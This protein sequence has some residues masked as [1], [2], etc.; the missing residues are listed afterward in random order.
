MDVLTRLTRRDKWSLAGGK[1]ALS[2]PPFPKHLTAPGFWDECYLAD[3][4]LPRLFTV[5]FLRDGKPLRLRG[6]VIDW[7]PSRLCLR[8]ASDEVTIEEIR[9]VT[10]ENAFI[11]RF[12]LL[13]GS[14]PIDAFL[15][16]LLDVREQGA[17]A[18]WT[19]LGEVKV[20]A[21][22]IVTSWQTAWPSDLEPDRSGVEDER[23]SGGPKMGPPAPVW[24]AFGAD[25]PRQ[26]HTVNLA[27][28]H[29]E[30]PLYELSVLP[31][32]F[33]NGRLPG[34][35]K[36]RVGVPP[37]EGLVHLVAQYRLESDGPLVVACGSG[38]TEE[39]ARRSLDD[40]RQGDIAA[41]SAADWTAYFAS[42]P[43]LESD[44]PFLTNAYWY[45]WYGLSLN[46]VDL[47]GFTL[48]TEDGPAEAGPFITEG[49]GFF[50]NFVS[51]SAQAHLREVSWMT[52]PRLAIGILDNLAT[53][54]R[55]DGSFPGHSYSGR[56]PRDFYHADFGTPIRQI[57][58]RHPEAIDRPHLGALRRYADYLLRH[59]TLSKDPASPTMYDVFDQNETG[60]EYMSRYQFASEAADRW[61]SFRVSGVDAT[62]YA[63]RTFAALADFR[64]VSSPYA[65]FA[66]GARQ[67]L[68]SLAWD[69][70]AAFF[71]DVLAGERSP[72]RPATGLYPLLVPG[73]ETQAIEAAK[74]WLA[75]PD[76]FWLTAGFPATAFSDATFSAESEW[77]QRRTNCPWNGRSWPMANCHL[78][79]GLA[80]LARATGAPDLRRLAGEA[81]LKTVHL[82]FHD[83]DPNRP[84]SF[85]HYDP[86]HGTPALYRG[87]DDYMHSWI[88]D[89]ILRHAAGLT[90][91]SNERD[92][93][94]KGVET[95]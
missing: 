12:S 81:L 19:S 88:A 47:A 71:C 48:L 59:R 39:A 16:S 93:L 31:D 73:L 50:R 92:P 61:Q 60:Q 15:W 18:P 45:H 94:L 56:P 77:R 89:L 29:D 43:Q 80:R 17:G 46:T 66:E 52:D 44:D 30:S 10:A 83:G 1:G 20:N 58:A 64:L 82:M 67:G 53:V 4:R 75:N 76:E 41:R 14:G 78:V 72:A 25:A 28:R 7:N 11:S 36:L 70:E 40:A 87:Y 79:D 6:E 84:N 27:Q 35:F 21:E 34:D 62:V 8:Y 54:Q 74:R 26:S 32:K 13:R 63:E 68:A 90:P 33:R 55:Q 24:L 2:A 51:Y 91:G 5:L 85:E 65:A 22:I 95:V 86:I 42:V 38:L 49:P 23:V 9:C 57:F 3:R 37:V 69:P